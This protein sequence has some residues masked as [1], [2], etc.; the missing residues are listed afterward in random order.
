MT[1]RITVIAAVAAAVIQP[2]MIRAEPPPVKGDPIIVRP[3][4]TEAERHKQLRDFTREV[5]RPPRMKQPVAKFFYPVCVSVIGLEAEAAGVIAARIRENAEALGV[6][7]DPKPDCTPTI[8]VAFMA[9]AAGPPAGWL[10]MKSPQ[11]AH[12]ASYQRERV[13]AESGPV[14]AWNRVVVRDF[15]GQPLML[16]TARAF[17]DQARFPDFAQIDPQSRTDPIVTTEITA[18]AVLIARDAADGLT[19]GQLADY[20]TMRTL[21][22]T[23]AP[24]G[25]AP[26]PTI[27]TLFS[28]PQTP[29]ELTD[30]DRALVRELYDASRNAKPRRV[31]N[32]IARAATAAERSDKGRNQ[33]PQ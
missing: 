24:E 8:R 9:L 33:A 4:L 20:A 18:A 28:D 22:G 5:I 19:L 1:A 16:A 21:L 2:A 26:A 7:A 30:F 11:L 10:S 6:G 31:F 3:P 29:A 15:N 25:V 32:D 13:L 14:R 27:L 17:G 23:G 12:L